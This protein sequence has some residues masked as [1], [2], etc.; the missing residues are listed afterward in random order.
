MYD[1]LV[2]RANEAPTTI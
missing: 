1:F 2:M